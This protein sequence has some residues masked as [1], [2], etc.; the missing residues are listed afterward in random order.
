MIFTDITSVGVKGDGMTDNSAAIQA[1]LNL[2]GNWYFP[3]GAYNF[4]TTLNITKPSTRLVGANMSTSKLVYKG[5]GTAISTINQSTVTTMWCSFEDLMLYTPNIT[6][7]FI[8]NFMSMQQCRIKN[9]WLIGS[10]SAN[11]TGLHIGAN[12]VVTE[13][14]YNIIEGCYIGLVKN[15]IVFT[16]GANNNTI[17]G[18]RFQPSVSGGNGVL[19]LGSAP[20]R[21]SCN[22]II[23]NGFEYPGKISNGIYL[24]ANAYNTTV[25][26]N[27]F[28]QLATG[29]YI[30]PTSLNTKDTGQYYSG[31]TSNKVGS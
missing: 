4:N 2:G 22:S 21:I 10:G 6:I 16:D 1:A 17:I 15:G 14:T 5:T 7:G 29:L 11:C 28:E 12:W 8:L 19:M 30:G 23:S 25:I 18:C 31:C 3:P 27:R 20:D 24:A 13:G 9:L 26:G